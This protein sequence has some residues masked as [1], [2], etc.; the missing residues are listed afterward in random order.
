MGKFLYYAV[1]GNGTAK[2]YSKWSDCKAATHR[3]KGMKFK[4][5]NSLEK[6][7]E[8]LNDGSTQGSPTVEKQ[9]DNKP[10]VPYAFVDG[11][12]NSTTNVYGCG[13]FLRTE[14]KEYIIQESGCDAELTTMRNVSGEILGA[15]A[16]VS[17]AKELGLTSLHIYYDYQGIESWATGAW[18]TNKNATKAYKEFMQSSG[19][20]I[21]F[22]KVKGHSGIDGNERADV[23]AK[24]AVGIIH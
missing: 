1:K 20:T 7:N 3:K 5:F 10:L 2:I 8:F 12:F 24:E 16:A 23:L 22:H 13:G 14:K 4:G 9:I 21:H 19:L 18:K 6:A 17:K 11:S 15:M